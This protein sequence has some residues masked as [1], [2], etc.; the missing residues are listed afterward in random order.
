MS[1]YSQN[2]SDMEEMVPVFL[3]PL[4]QFLMDTL[5][6]VELLGACP[7]HYYYH[8]ILC[9]GCWL[10]MSLYIINI[11]SNSSFCEYFMKQ[12]KHYLLL[13][14]NTTDSVR[15]RYFHKMKPLHNNILVLRTVHFK[16]NTK[17]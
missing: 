6:S 16:S 14:F 10:L 15:F 3:E 4:V 8:N 9:R 2:T 13:M 12:L 1:R 7:F 11:F 5:L 17:D